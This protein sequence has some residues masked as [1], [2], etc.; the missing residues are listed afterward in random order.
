MDNTNLP[1]LPAA[2]EG[3]VEVCAVVRLYLA[4]IDDLSEEQVETLNA[5]VAACAAC[6][7]EFYM[8]RRA[9]D[10]VSSFAAS[11]PS[12]RVD[13][14][15]RAMIDGQSTRAAQKRRR[16]VSLQRPISQRAAARNRYRGVAGWLVAAA[17][18]AM[19]LFASLQFTGVIDGSRTQ[20]AFA[21]PAHLTWGQYVLYHT[22]TRADANGQHYQ[23][24]SYDDLGSGNMHVETKM[25]DQLDI[26]VVG[27]KSATL[28][29]DMIHH[30]AQMD[31]VE[32]VVDDSLFDLSALRHNIQMK[33]D[34][35]LDT[36]TY[37]GQPVYRIRCQD[38]LVM[39]LDMQ[40]RPVNVLSANTG[41]P[42]YTSLQLIPASRVSSSMWDMSIPQGF[43][44]GQLPAQP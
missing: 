39:L 3:G 41:Q 33:S 40:Y 1:P 23:V 10:L 5:H 24:E 2:G 30:V 15:I 8:L 19:A 37:R 17:V 38:N 32:W 27:D 28:G 26:V 12:P 34:V 31:T 35:Y 18:I 36:E 4:V 43:H 22:E 44:M 6:G 9:A 13:A 16:P 29:L 14:A 21:L 25:D 42:I 11:A 7:E 20:T